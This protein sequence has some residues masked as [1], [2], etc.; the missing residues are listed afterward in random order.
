MSRFK[1]TDPCIVEG[2]SRQRKTDVQFCARCWAEADDG[3]RAQVLFAM[4]APF[5]ITRWGE[6]YA[7]GDVMF[8]G[9]SLPVNHGAPYVDFGGSGPRHQVHFARVLQE[10]EERATI[11]V[12]AERI[13]VR[14]A[15]SPSEPAEPAPLGDDDET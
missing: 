14:R 15:F 5:F 9:V 4:H 6:D 8:D 12:V 7:P 13:R 3:E 1:V 10:Y 2:C 11:R